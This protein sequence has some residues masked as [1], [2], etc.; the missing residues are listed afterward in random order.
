MKLF[1]SNSGG[2]LSV[3]IDVGS[4]SV[5]VAYVYKK[6]ESAVPEIIWSQREHI[7]LR[8]NA[9]ADQLAKNLLSA[10]MNAAI[11]LE[12]T[13]R[14]AV[15]GVIPQH[16]SP[17]DIFVSVAAPWSYTINKT[18]SYSTDDS[19][20]V[21]K[22]LI[23]EL[24][25]TA[26][27]KTGEELEEQEVAYSLGLSITIQSTVAILANSYPIHATTGQQASS[28]AISRLTG[29][30]QTFLVNTLKELRDKTFPNATL[31]IHPF[32]V[33]YYETLRAL[34]PDSTE[35]GLV[36]VTYE[37]TEIGIVREGVLQYCT[38][39]AS[40]AFSVAREMALEQNISTEEALGAIQN[41]GE[42]H[43][44][45][46]QS[47]IDRYEKALVDLFKETGDRLSVPKTVYLHAPGATYAFLEQ[48]IINAGKN[49]TSGEMFV[50]P[51]T[52]TLTTS[53]GATTSQHDTSLQ[54]SLW[55]F[56][57]SKKKGT[58]EW[59]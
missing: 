43:S 32:M 30:V 27:T 51:L 18:I 3:L 26:A 4:A 7:P 31:R 24:E 5:M 58:H 29:V 59:L 52:N 40:G 57:T 12:T 6:S 49:A 25:H 23:D 54:V 15:E 16:H 35:V 13:G 14:K 17:K 33:A 10:L 1:G 45:P 34:E 42:L 44:A 19:F 2:E 20:P 53:A 48:R 41:P 22:S 9:Q 8:Q 28:L 55:F 56:H 21:T 36:D 37:A 50:K 11:A 39:V 38:H 47:Q 46:N